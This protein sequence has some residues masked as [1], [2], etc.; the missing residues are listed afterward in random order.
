MD[1]LIVICGLLKKTASILIILRVKTI[2]H[3][4]IQDQR[5]TLNLQLNL[6]CDVVSEL[7]VNKLD[8]SCLK[9]IAHK[10]PL[11]R[12]KMPLFLLYMY[13]NHFAYLII[14]DTFL[15]YVKCKNKLIKA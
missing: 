1:I 12:G 3:N 10:W 2:K 4:L 14:L 9:Q 13:L 5:E 15:Q 8:K 7:C 11:N 6:I